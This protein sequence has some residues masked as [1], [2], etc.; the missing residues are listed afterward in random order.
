MKFQY[1][2][3]LSR[4]PVV[5][6]MVGFCIVGVLC[7]LISNLATYGLLRQAKRVSRGKRISRRSM[8]KHL[9]DSYR[10]MVRK[11]IVIEDLERYVQEA[12]AGAKAFG[13]SIAQLEN[14]NLTMMVVCFTL[15]AV[16][17]MIAYLNGSSDSEI[18]FVF[19]IGLA[20]TGIC[21]IVEVCFHND[22]YRMMYLIGMQNY[23]ENEYRY[24]ITAELEHEEEA[25]QATYKEVE[26]EVRARNYAREVEPVEYTSE[27]VPEFQFRE[28]TATGIAAAKELDDEMLEELLRGMLLESE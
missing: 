17:S 6:V 25:R 18:V 2:L 27:T 28:P 15:G 22:Y 4:W 16:N 5:Y 8:T 7:K 9:L 11:G 19:T 10:K 26:E 20:L 24:E 1:E 23:L 14:T 3:W 21:V 12:L 13:V